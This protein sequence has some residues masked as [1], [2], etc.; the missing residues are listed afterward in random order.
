MAGRKNRAVRSKAEHE[1][2]AKEVREDAA[3]VPEVTVGAARDPSIVV[4]RAAAKH[5]TGIPL[6][7]I[8]LYFTIISIFL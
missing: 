3:R 7:F 4:E 8:T 6:Q 5:T 1:G 2:S